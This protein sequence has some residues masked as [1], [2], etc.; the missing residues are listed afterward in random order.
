MKTQFISYTGCLVLASVLIA[1]CESGGG[2]GGW[3][4]SAEVGDTAPDFFIQDK[5]G[6]ERP[7]KSL[8]G[9]YTVVAFSPGVAGQGSAASVLQKIMADTGK[10]PSTVLTAVDVHWKADETDRQGKCC[11]TNQ[12]GLLVSVA[13][14]TGGVRKLYDVDEGDV[15]LVLNRDREILAR[16]SLANADKISSLLKDKLAALSKQR[17]S[18][19]S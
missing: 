9:D 7:F 2:T 15:L 4:R 19:G 6:T 13:D 3:G 14:E 11:I 18:S 1:G 8:A 16:E 12:Q 5:A 10:H 17:T